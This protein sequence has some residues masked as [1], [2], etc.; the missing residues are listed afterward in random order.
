VDLST[1]ESFSKT[2]KTKQFT[3]SNGD[4][5]T[6]RVLSGKGRDGWNAA[7]TTASATGIGTVE[8]I[9]CALLVRAICT[10][11]GARVFDDGETVTLAESTDSKV[12]EEMFNFA[13]QFNQMGKQGEVD[14]KK[15]SPESADSGSVSPAS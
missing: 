8:G 13:F 5:C 6:L 1:K 7:V 9:Y 10:P 11:D 14:A 4:T 15:A 2:I 12:L 3:L